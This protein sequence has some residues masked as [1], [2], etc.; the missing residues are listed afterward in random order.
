M[1][2]V[3]GRK[4]RLL[5]IVEENI[6]QFDLT[7]KSTAALRHPD[8]AAWTRRKG[9]NVKIE[10]PKIQGNTNVHPQKLKQRSVQKED[11]GN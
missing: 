3:E 11:L 10:T 5:Y 8:L 9:Q 6:S 7:L 4:D 1:K 2:Y